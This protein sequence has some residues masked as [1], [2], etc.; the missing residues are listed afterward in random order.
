MAKFLNTSGVSYRLELL[1]KNAK[2]K[3]IL[4]SPFLKFNDRIKQLIE[5]QDRL[6]LDIRLVYGKNELQPEE[7]NY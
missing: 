3:L 7:N 1:V 6:K 4:I 5:D 2:E